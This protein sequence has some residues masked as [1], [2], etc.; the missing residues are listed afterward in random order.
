MVA[1]FSLLLLLL[2]LR[3]IAC[4]SFVCL[5]PCFSLFGPY[6][7]CSFLAL[8]VLSSLFACFSLFDP[9]PRCSF[10][11]LV[12][13]SS[14]CACFSLFGPYP[15][16]SSLS[17]VA[18]SFLFACS[19]LFG[20]YP[21][22]FFILVV[23]SSL[24]ACFSLFGP[25]PRCSSLSLVA[26]SFL[27]ACSSLFGPYPRSFFI[28]VVLSSQ[29]ACFCLSGPYSRCSLLPLVVLSFL[30][31]LNLSEADVTSLVGGKVIPL[32]RA[33]EPARRHVSYKLG[34]DRT[35]LPLTELFVGQLASPGVLTQPV[36]VSSPGL[37]VYFS[38]GQRQHQPTSHHE[39]GAEFVSIQRG[40]GRGREFLPRSW[41]VHSL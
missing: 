26:L 31:N 27:F 13:L 25:Y 35:S 40:S 5:L 38:S 30:R 11:T 29:F 32:C 3:W 9:Y 28:L 2:S 10:L 17:L 23:L 37:P 8:V 12:V 14:L 39:P 33:C 15:R 36:C 4:L 6:P 20:P 22:S 24:C 7:R 19:S 18:L 16:C 34:R 41:H 1:L 21:R